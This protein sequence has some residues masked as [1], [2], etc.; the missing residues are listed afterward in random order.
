MNDCAFSTF[1]IYG[2]AFL[3][4]A[5]YSTE[6]YFTLHLH[7]FV[8]NSMN[9]NISTEEYRKGLST[10][11]ASVLSKL[12]Y[13]GKSIFSLEDL[14]DLV[15]NPTRFV[16]RL[17]RKKW[18]GKLKNGLY[19]LAPLEAG[20]TGADA[21]TAHPFLI[22][23]YLTF[24]YYIGY[25]TALNH[26]GLTETVP[27]AIYV[28]T[29]KALHDKFILNRKYVMVMLNTSKF[30]GLEEVRVEDRDVTI[31]NVEKTLADCLDHPEHCGGVGEIARAFATGASL[32]AERLLRYARKMK[33]RTILKR[34]GFLA[35]FLD[36][37]DIVNDIKRSELSKGYSIL[38]PSL[39]VS[40]GTSDRWGLRINAD[41]EDW[42]R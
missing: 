42:L 12:S 32:N 14:R 22:A 40:G 21:H 20:E 27:P 33:N 35:E 2:H 37:P 31:S 29:T 6:S 30:F 28:A 9:S 1:P 15:P 36:I 16:G 18:L 13:S 24:P 41:L 11:E 5:H 23:S 25:W 39:P 7:Y 34:L 38:D 8:E 4:F 10:A 19:I 3:G 17:L 26:H